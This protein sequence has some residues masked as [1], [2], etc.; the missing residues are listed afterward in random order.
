MGQRT[1]PQL[2][3]GKILSWIGLLEKYNIEHT[4]GASAHVEWDSAVR[5]NK[6]LPNIIVV[7]K[8]NNE[9]DEGEEVESSRI[10]KRHREFVWKRDIGDSKSGKCYVCSCTITDDNFET[11]HI[12]AKSEGGSNHVSNLKAICKPCNG[13]MGTMNLEYFKK[14]FEANSTHTHKTIIRQNNKFSD[15]QIKN[16]NNNT[17]L[18]WKDSIKLLKDLRNKVNNDYKDAL[19]VAINNLELNIENF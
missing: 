10:T 7:T 6:K 13:A 17:V 14:D 15:T 8:D 16:I 12:I 5:Y 19:T 3:N 4:E 2:P 9:N 1:Y 11:G 18:M